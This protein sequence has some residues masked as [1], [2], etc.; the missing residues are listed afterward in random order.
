MYRI[1][2]I[3]EDFIVE[4]QIELDFDEDGKYTYF[5]LDKKSCNTEDAIISISK[6]LRIPRNAFNY[7]GAKDKNA[8]T[9]QCV[10]VRGSIRNFEN[11][12]IKVKVLGKGNK[13][14]LLG[15]LTKNKFNLIIRKVNERPE[16]I[17]FIPNYFD[18]QRFGR[19]NLQ[20][21]LN[22]LKKDFK[23]A[24]KSIEDKRTLE[25]LKNNPNNS[26]GAIRCIPF[27]IL[28]MYINSVQSYIF[29]EALNI[30]IKENSK[31]LTKV[32][33]KQGEFFFPKEFI[34]I[35]NLPLISFDT[36]YSNSKLEN[37]YNEILNNNN[38]TKNNFIIRS[39]SNITPHGDLRNAFVEVEDLNIS[40]LYDDELNKNKN[41]I[42]IDFSL[43]KGS[44][45][46]VVIKSLF[47]K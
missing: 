21:G 2:Q 28:K 1:K 9:K 41:K 37:I 38:L 19:N 8:L 4:E 20:I 15:Q 24:A 40:E 44:Y 13:P 39:I 35:E 7:A 14:I 46:T 16:K 30:L 33:Y 12:E 25:F 31:N 27:I 29:N 5:Q 36:I 22:I 26:I 3:P 32:D 43:S 10:S 6:K 11:N 23:N 17:S 18:D 42:K 34:E 45:A 47:S